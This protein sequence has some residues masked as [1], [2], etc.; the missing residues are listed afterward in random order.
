MSY[1]LLRNCSIWNASSSSYALLSVSS[2]VITF[3][4]LSSFDKNVCIY[5]RVRGREFMLWGSYYLFL[6]KYIYTLWKYSAFQW[7]MKIFRWV[8]IEFFEGGGSKIKENVRAYLG[9]SWY[10]LYVP[11]ALPTIR[12]RSHLYISAAD[13]AQQ[14]RSSWFLPPSCHEVDLNSLIVVPPS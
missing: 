12:Y 2:T 1:C 7:K 9:S 11:L 4:V 3:W 8:Q 6:P 10:K 13:K 14:G 5:F